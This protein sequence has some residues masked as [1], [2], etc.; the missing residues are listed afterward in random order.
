V[1]REQK[2]TCQED[3]DDLRRLRLVRTV[4]DQDVVGCCP[5]CGHRL[6]AVEPLLPVDPVVDVVPDRAAFTAALRTVV[7]SESAPPP[8]MLLA[9]PDDAMASRI[10]E[11]AHQRGVYA[12]WCRDGAEAFAALG[13]LGRTCW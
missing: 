2:E 7:L 8:L 6:G 4:L 9:E 5:A 1:F 11:A 10:L 3:R 13:L 12:E